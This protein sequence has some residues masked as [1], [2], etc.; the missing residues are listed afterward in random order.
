MENK[1][2]SNQETNSYVGKTNE[3][4]IKA[5][6]TTRMIAA[7]AIVA[8]LYCAITV[9]CFYFSFGMVQFR[10]SEILNLLVFFNPAYTIGLTIGCLLSNAI[11]LGMNMAGPWDLLIGTGATLVGCLLMIPFK[12]LLLA[13]FMPVIVNAVVVGA[14]LTWLMNAVTPDLWWVSMGYV[15]LGEF[16]VINLVGY[17]LFLILDKKYPTIMKTLLATRNLDFNW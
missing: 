13:S 8:A 7:N 9:A 2:Y 17:P 5:W 15:F 12:H 11:G 10:V 6:F 14:E 4:G 16:V 3:K 1:F